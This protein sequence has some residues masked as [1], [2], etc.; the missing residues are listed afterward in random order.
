MV[1]KK[2]TCKENLK[3]KKLIKQN[4]LVKEIALEL[5]RTKDAIYTKASH[6]KITLNPLKE[7]PYERHN[8]KHI[9]TK[10]K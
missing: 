4:M 10:V 7:T 3:M 1:V 2:W 9:K 6:E 8:R 5:G